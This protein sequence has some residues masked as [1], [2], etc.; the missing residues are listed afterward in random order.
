MNAV[1][2]RNMYH[3]FCEPHS[4]VDKNAAVLYG[5]VAMIGSQDSSV[6]IAARYGLDGPEIKSQ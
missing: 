6:G 3:R 1:F 2:L 5:T 4:Y